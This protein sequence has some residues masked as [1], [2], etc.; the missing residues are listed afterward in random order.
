MLGPDLND[1]LGLSRR[2]HQRAAFVDIQRQRFFGVNIL[3]G[4]TGFDARLDSLE[5]ARGHNHRI[6]V[7][8]I[9]DFAVI[10]VHRPV[11]FDFF[12]KRQGSWLIA[13]GCRDDLRRLRELFEQQRPTSPYSDCTDSNPFAS[14]A[15]V[16]GASKPV[17]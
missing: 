11:A 10:G 15:W 8:S 4:Q 1:S 6:D 7:V 14:P 5:L 12:A 2:S 9:E 13:I 17:T 16:S 3:A